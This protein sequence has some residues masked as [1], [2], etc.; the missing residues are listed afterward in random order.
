MT[1][2]AFDIQLNAVARVEADTEEEARK[3]LWN[4]AECL[5]IGMVTPDG[6]RFTEAGAFGPTVLLEVDGEG[7]GCNPVHSYEWKPD[8]RRQMHRTCGAYICLDCDDHEGLARCYCGWARDGGNG[9]AQLQE[10]GENVED[11]Y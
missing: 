11:D 2:Y 3:K 5:D 7:P 10:L 1:E 8:G 4:Y 6:V 9:V